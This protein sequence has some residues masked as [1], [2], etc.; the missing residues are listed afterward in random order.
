M[1]LEGDALANDV[2]DREEAE[3]VFVI[4]EDVSVIVAPQDH[5]INGPGYV[6]SALFGHAASIPR[7]IHLSTPGTMWVPQA[8]QGFLVLED[9]PVPVPGPVHLDQFPGLPVADQLGGNDP[10]TGSRVLPGAQAP[11]LHL[12]DL[13]GEFENKNRRGLE[14]KTDGKNRRGLEMDMIDGV[15]RSRPRGV[16]LV[17]MRWGDALDFLK[18]L[19]NGVREIASFHT[20]WSKS[21]ISKASPPKTQRKTHQ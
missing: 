4:G 10:L 7:D 1:D 14:T 15:S 13:S 9:G 2:E 20:K 12:L 3:P 6:D 8:P 17:R 5:V 16:P 19:R 18:F 11:E 21:R